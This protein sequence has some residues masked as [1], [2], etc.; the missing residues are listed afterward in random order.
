M[1]F[2]I[3]S[4]PIFSTPILAVL[5]WRA[6]VGLWTIVCI[7]ITPIV[8]VYF[9]NRLQ[10]RTAVILDMVT[11][12]LELKRKAIQQDQGYF[13]KVIVGNPIHQ[14][15]LKLARDTNQILRQK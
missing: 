9:A 2:L 10:N 12:V 3:L 8:S 13:D 7:F 6:V 14:E 15:L 11:E 5:T 4:A 1:D